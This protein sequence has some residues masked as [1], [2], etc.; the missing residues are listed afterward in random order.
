MISSPYAGYGE[1]FENLPMPGP[2]S[3]DSESN[4]QGDDT[5]Q[6]GLRTTAPELLTSHQREPTHTVHTGPAARGGLATLSHVH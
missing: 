4:G 3:R 2:T 5:M 1:L 6:L